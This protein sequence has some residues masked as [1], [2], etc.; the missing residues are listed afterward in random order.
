MANQHSD[1]L[2]T[3]SGDSMAFQRNRY[4]KTISGESVIDTR[5]D[6]HHPVA[7]K[8]AYRML[9][10]ASE[11]RLEKLMDSRVFGTIVFKLLYAEITIVPDEQTSGFNIISC[12]TQKKVN[13]DMVEFFAR[14]TQY[15]DSVHLDL[16]MVCLNRS[17]LQY[18]LLA[19]NLLLLLRSDIGSK[20]EYAKCDCPLMCQLLADQV[21]NM[22][23]YPDFSRH[24]PHFEM[25][26]LILDRCC[27]T[28]DDDDINMFFHVLNTA[29]EDSIS[30][31][32]PRETLELCD[33]FSRFNIEDTNCTFWTG[34]VN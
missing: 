19:N 3:V 29:S 6:D 27:D 5:Y 18:R 24:F 10:Q 21:V 9:Y 15:I 25:A 17:P 4:L 31:L 12:Y 20:I 2:N 32:P 1:Y 33:S 28:V 30:S 11:E 26:T 7:W 14:F 22:A 34:C 23:F 13:F 16:S 8:V